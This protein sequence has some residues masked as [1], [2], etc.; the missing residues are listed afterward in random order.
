M[1]TFD[2][3]MA[4]FADRHGIGSLTRD[5]EG[6]YRLSFDDDLDLRCFERFNYL[7]MISSIGALPEVPDE[8]ARWLGL[9]LNFALTRMKG[10]PT[11]PAMDANGRIELF[12]RFNDVQ[13]MRATALDENVEQ[14]LNCLES[15]RRVLKRSSR[16]TVAAPRE[17]VFRP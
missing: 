16:P 2:V 12:S 13:N 9:L 11:T 14:H 7:H 4:E 6:G 10:L 17:M 5:E 15:F 8:R 3:L 1:A